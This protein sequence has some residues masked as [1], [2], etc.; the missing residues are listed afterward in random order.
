MYELAEVVYVLD[1]YLNNFLTELLGSL[2]K[3]DMLNEAFVGLSLATQ[4]EDT[5]PDNPSP[6]SSLH[7]PTVQ[8]RTL[9]VSSN[10]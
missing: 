3:E 4:G 2:E 7:R 5:F 10:R 8:Q 6:F 9:N 1:S